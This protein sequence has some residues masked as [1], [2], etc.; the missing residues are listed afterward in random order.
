MVL[1]MR[2]DN[3]MF[4]YLQLNDSHRLW[5]RLIEHY[6]LNHGMLE[7]KILFNTQVHISDAGSHR[8]L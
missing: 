1:T 8:I 2:Y 4:L 3:E 5:E 6:V 7:K